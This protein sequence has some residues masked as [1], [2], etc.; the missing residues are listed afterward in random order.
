MN[1]PVS[2]PMQITADHMDVVPAG[3]QSRT[4]WICLRRSPELTSKGILNIAAD[5]LLSTFWFLNAI[6]NF[7][8]LLLIRT[9]LIRVATA[10][11][12][13]NPC[14]LLGRITR[15]RSSRQKP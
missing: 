7:Y 1:T 12:M 2:C 4:N 10:M 3:L 5:C 13:I 11:V 8:F 14:V 9:K 15:N 6:I